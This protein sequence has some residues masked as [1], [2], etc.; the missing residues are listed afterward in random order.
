MKN[1]LFFYTLI[2]PN[3]EEWHYLA[4]KKILFALLRWKRSKHHSDFY[5]LS[6]LHSSAAENKRESHKNVC[7]NK[8][9]YNAVMPFK[10]SKILEFN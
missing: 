2:I 5:F 4:V 10:D 3:K 9:F 8:D 7:E 1:K 6:C